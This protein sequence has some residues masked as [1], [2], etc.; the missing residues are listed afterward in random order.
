MAADDNTT[1]CTD[2]FTADQITQLALVRLVSG[3]VSVFACCLAIV[4]MVICQAFRSTLQRLFLYITAALTAN[5]VTLIFVI[6]D[7][8]HSYYSLNAKS[9]ALM[10]FLNLYTAQIALSFSI[11]TALYLYHNIRRSNS[12]RHRPMHTTRFTTRLEVFFVF[13]SIVLPLTYSWTPFI[14]DAYGA[15]PKQPFCWIRIVNSDCSRI[16]A[17]F[18]YYI[19]LGYVPYLIVGICGTVLM[20]IITATCC[21]WVRR[22]RD[23]RSTFTHEPYTAL[24]LIA[25]FIF[26]FLFAAVQL[27]VHVA[28]RSTEPYR[29]LLLYAI[30]HP[31]IMLTI[32]VLFIVQ[33]YCYRRASKRSWKN[34]C[35]THTSEDRG[36][37]QGQSEQQETSPISVNPYVPSHTCTYFPSTST[38]TT[39]NVEA[40][41]AKSNMNVY[42]S[43]N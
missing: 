8:S 14:H 5:A 19:I 33:L 40:A 39:Q 42:G 6:D 26:I 2:Y 29:L 24:L 12:H 36:K 38:D 9:C 10:G 7:H 20:F 16:D 17:G 18:W 3:S 30:G 25:Y 37:I 1:N 34:C 27:V 15:S 21:R 28:R 31:V 4:L 22:Y 35:R 43:F 13:F 32:P 41:T 11:G 23:I